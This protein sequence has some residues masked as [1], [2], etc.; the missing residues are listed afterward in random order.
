[1]LVNGIPLAVIEAKTP[2]RASQSWFDAAVQIH[3]DYERNVPE[4][5]VPNANLHRHRGQ[6]VPVRVYRS[7]G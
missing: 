4:L 2:V 5:F 3:D 7:A 1:M 6:R